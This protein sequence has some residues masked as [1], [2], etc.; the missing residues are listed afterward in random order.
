MG[1]TRCLWLLASL[2]LAIILNGAGCAHHPPGARQPFTV[3][4][5]PDTQMY[6][7]NRPDLFYAQTE[8]IKTNRDTRNIVFVTQVG[9]IINDRSKIMEQWAVAS[10]AMAK[11]DGVVSWGVT[12]GN[13]DYDSDKLKEGVA[14][15][16]LRYF[17]PDRFKGHED[18]GGSSPNGLNSY[19]LFS[20][21][22]VQ[23]IILQLEV[24]VPDEAIRWAQNVLNQHP[25]H[26]AI[27][28]THSYL[29]GREG[30][31]RNRQHDLRPNGNS[32]QS[33]WEKFVEPNPQVFMVLCGH[34]GRTDEYYQVSTNCAG[35][36]VLEMLADYQSRTNGGD[37][38]LRLIRFLPE[39]RQIQMITYSPALV[40]FETDANS[41]FVVPWE[42]PRACWGK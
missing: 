16:W 3:V 41:Q 1:V 22:G 26:A 13:H 36:R 2:G 8:W 6:S 25:R 4:M 5:L 29:K 34:E 7:K 11:L 18:Y 42:M 10:N 17:G 37:G 28:A 21:G 19:H 14:T 30:I 20:A 38:W 40:K 27:V 23:F 24:N 32:G 35:N 31:T 39:S 9:D 33:L 15:V 12:I